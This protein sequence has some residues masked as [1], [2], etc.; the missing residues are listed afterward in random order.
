MAMLRRRAA[1]GSDVEATLLFSSRGWD[2][3]IYRQELDRLEGNGLKVVHTLTRSQP[4]GW[5]GY[6]RRVDRNMLAEVA[7]P[8][9]QRPQVYVCGPT[10]FVEAVAEG[11]VALGHAPNAIRTE[12]F[13]PTGG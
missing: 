5:H 8:P 2:D 6:A 9:Q 13:G 12:R 4:P 7:P 3:V 1:V 11:L 10:P